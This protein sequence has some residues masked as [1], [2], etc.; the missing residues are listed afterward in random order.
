VVLEV[1]GPG[2]DALEIGVVVEEDM[3]WAVGGEVSCLIGWLAGWSGWFAYEVQNV[4]KETMTGLQGM[5]CVGAGA[6][7]GEKVENE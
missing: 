3:W 4:Q 5:R 1:A 6:D 2:V 7:A